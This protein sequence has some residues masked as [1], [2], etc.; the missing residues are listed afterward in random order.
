MASVH[1]RV[2]IHVATLARAGVY[3]QAEDMAVVARRIFAQHNRP[4]GHEIEVV[5]ARKDSHVC[6]EGRA[7]LSVEFGRSPDSDGKGA[8]RGLHILGRTMESF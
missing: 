2:H 5:H 3:D 8:M 4:G 6:L 1:A 7:P